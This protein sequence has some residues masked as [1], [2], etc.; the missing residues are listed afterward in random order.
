MMLSWKLWDCHIARI[1]ANI[2]V[3]YYLLPHWLSSDPGND[4]HFAHFADE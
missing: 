3:Q 1:E 4:N 2:I